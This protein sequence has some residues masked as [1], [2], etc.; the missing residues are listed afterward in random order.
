M[1]QLRKNFVLIYAD[2]SRLGWTRW[3]SA[4]LTWGSLIW[5]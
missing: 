2:R 5:E 4:G 3:G 1:R